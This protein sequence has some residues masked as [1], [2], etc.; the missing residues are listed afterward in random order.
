VDWRQA[1]FAVF[2]FGEAD[3]SFD[4]AVSIICRYSTGT[5]VARLRPISVWRSSAVD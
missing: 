4:R 5:L 3:F 2:E 1:A